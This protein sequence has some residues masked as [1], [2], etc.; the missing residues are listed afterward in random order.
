MDSITPSGGKE[1]KTHQTFH[2]VSHTSQSALDFDG[3]MQLILTS[4]PYKALK[5]HLDVLGERELN[6]G[7]NVF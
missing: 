2:S 4:G 3:A 7:A 6:L 5:L 1:S